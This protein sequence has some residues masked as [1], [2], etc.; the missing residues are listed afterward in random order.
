MATITL[1]SSQSSPLTNTQVDAN[2]SNINTQLE[3]VVNIT[4]PTLAPKA[5]PA[6]NGTPT[7][8]TASLRT[9]TTQIASTA[10]VYSELEAR[11][12]AA[13]PAMSG[14]AFIGST[15]R[16]AR[17]DHVHPTDATRAPIA[18]P[19][20]TGTVTSDYFSGNGSSLIN[21]NASSL[22]SGTVPTARLTVASLATVGIT[23]LQ[24]TIDSSE[25]KAA[26]P[27]AVKSAY[28]LANA[29]LPK[30]GGTMLGPIVLAGPAT[31]D[32]NP[33]TKKQLDDATP[34][35]STSVAG[36]VELATA[37][38][39][40]ALTDSSRAITP[41]TLA[42]G[43]KSSLSASGDA[44]VFGVRAWVSFDGT[45]AAN[46]SGTYSQTGTEVTV[47]VENHGHK[48]GHQIYVKIDSGAALSEIA[49]T[50]SSVLSPNQF[51][52]IS[53]PSLTTSGNITLS[54]R[55]I[56]G[57]GNVASVSY[58]GPG[59][60][61]INFS[62][63]MPDANYCVTPGIYEERGTGSGYMSFNTFGEKTKYCLRSYLYELRGSSNIIARVDR[64]KIDY[65]VFR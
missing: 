20:F 15:D 55:A 10:F 40:S 27:A 38:E 35:A 37:E 48:I 24:N 30:S 21:L 59:N 60:Y 4:I 18:S 12:S 58:M 39:T 31:T 5:S 53:G 22:S 19:T 3:Q 16:F 13:L 8:P 43:V 64:S 51:K 36:K 45:V 28:D 57:Q 33:V 9:N 46:V 23:S 7:T 61:V 63:E 2:F 32:L 17:E 26:T 50:V 47:T 44:P 1:R 62:Q 65:T 49:T 34:T 52:Y 11:K 14:T 25:T 54:R 42:G 6:F 41:S 56:V 29:A